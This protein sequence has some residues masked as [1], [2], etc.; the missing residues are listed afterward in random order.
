MYL[1]SIAIRLKFWCST[2]TRIIILADFHK[3]WGFWVQASWISI[4]S[5]CT[6]A[7]E[8]S[9][10]PRPTTWATPRSRHQTFV[11]VT[12]PLTIYYTAGAGVTCYSDAGPTSTYCMN[13]WYIIDWLDTIYLL[14]PLFL[15]FNENLNIKCFILRSVILPLTSMPQWHAMTING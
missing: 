10:L 11:S 9:R 6:N 7:L 14:T 8:W 5:L 15:F 13:K 2:P 3:F 12:A 4:A 1:R